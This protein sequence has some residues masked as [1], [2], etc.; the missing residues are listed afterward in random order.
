VALTEEGIIEVPGLASRWVRLASGAKAHYMTSGD[1]GPAVL[2][3][4]GGLPGSSGTAGW[5][6]MA[7]FLGANGFRVYAPDMPGYGLSD[8]AAEHR[9]RGIHTQ[10]DFIHEFVTALCLDKFH[11]A[12]NSMGCMNSAS[13]IV[14][15]PDK[16]LSFAL[17]AGEIGDITEHLTRPQGE[18]KI[19]MYDGTAESMRTMMSAIIYRPENISDDLVEMRHSA[20]VVHAEAARA[21]FPAMLEFANN[22][23]SDPN[24]AARLS[25]KGR[26]DKMTIPGIYLYG[27]DDVL[28]P[29]EWGYQQETVLPNVQFFFP[30]ECGHQGQTDQPDLFNQVFLEFFRDGKIARQTADAA[31]I[32]KHRPE[33]PSLVTQQ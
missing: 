1:T 14:A 7:P 4:H 16:I 29:V 33:N 8:P 31:G 9:P 17:I 21:Y 23:I 12:G 2:L 6:Y 10:V 11:I 32:S 18:A 15:H 20:S 28:I 30:A 19:P 5:R 25:T 27:Q 22:R 24:I 13:Y 26:L 3:L